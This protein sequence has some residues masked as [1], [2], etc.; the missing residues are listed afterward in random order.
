MTEKRKTVFGYVMSIGVC[1]LCV[2]ILI[3]ALLLGTLLGTALSSSALTNP[4]K[5]LSI[6]FNA[7]TISS[8][9]LKRFKIIHTNYTTRRDFFQV[10]NTKNNFIFS[11]Q[12]HRKGYGRTIAKSLFF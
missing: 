9:H 10:G 3:A 4:S 1:V 12:A 8:V 7:I 2:M 6:N 11:K 5:N